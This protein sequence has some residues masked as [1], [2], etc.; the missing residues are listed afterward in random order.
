MET[1]MCHIFNFLPFDMVLGMVNP[2]MRTV[3]VTSSG[4]SYLISMPFLLTCQDNTKF[5]PPAE[6]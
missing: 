1:K 4:K 6:S 3:N 5:F 2:F